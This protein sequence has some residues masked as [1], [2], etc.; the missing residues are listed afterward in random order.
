MVTTTVTHNIGP[1]PFM[2][3][4][5]RGPRKTPLPG[6]K[7]LLTA[8]GRC[9]GLTRA[10]AILRAHVKFFSHAPLSLLSASKGISVFQSKCGAAGTGSRLAIR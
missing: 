7:P 9:G 5:H 4:F 8:S 1:R 3:Q 10:Y 6:R 2:S